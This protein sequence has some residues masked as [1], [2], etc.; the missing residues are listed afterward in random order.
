MINNDLLLQLSDWYEVPRHQVN[1]ACGSL[2]WHY[3]SLEQALAAAYPEH[4]W[5]SDRFQKDSNW[6]N[7]ANQRAFLDRI[8]KELGVMEVKSKSLSN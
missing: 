6:S 3:D 2:L 8:G 4:P 5:K 1:I 7:P